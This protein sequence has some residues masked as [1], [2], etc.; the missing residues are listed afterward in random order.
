MMDVL[1][2]VVLFTAYGV[3]GAAVG[4]CFYRVMDRKDWDQDL[5]PVVGLLWPG[6]LFLLLGISC[7]E[8]ME[9]RD[10]RVEAEKEAEA[11]RKKDED[12]MLKREGFPMEDQS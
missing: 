9:R 10:E 3:V 8:W 4:V 2:G 5:A 1:A 11:K 6:G 7:I 12:E